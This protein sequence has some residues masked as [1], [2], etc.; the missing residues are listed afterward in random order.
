MKGN[1]VRKHE[2]MLYQRVVQTPIKIDF[3]VFTFNLNACQ[4][5]QSILLK[6]LFLINNHFVAIVDILP[7]I[8]E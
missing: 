5:I 3:Y 8:V 7:P 1:N 4:R 2:V 6:D